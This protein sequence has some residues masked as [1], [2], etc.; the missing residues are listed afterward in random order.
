MTTKHLKNDG[1]SPL[2]HLYSLIFWF[3][4]RWI[5]FKLWSNLVKMIFANILQGKKYGVVQTVSPI[6]CDF[7]FLT[8][9]L[10]FSDRVFS[11]N[12][13]WKVALVSQH[14]QNLKKIHHRKREKIRCKLCFYCLCWRHKMSGTPYDFMWAHADYY[15][16]RHQRARGH[17][18]IGSHLKFRIVFYTHQTL[19]NQRKNFVLYTL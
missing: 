13:L 15:S 12:S 10:N 19:E 2:I 8:I 14:L 18:P 7:L 16:S 17:K 5:F 9:K 11:K 4:P 1:Y 3:F 6:S